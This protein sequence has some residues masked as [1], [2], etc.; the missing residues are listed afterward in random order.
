[1]FKRILV[2]IDGSPPSTA[3][4]SAAIDL[5][6]DQRALVVALNVID[7]SALPVNFEGPALPAS[8]VDAYFAA[9]GEYAR[10]LVERARTA[11]LKRG[12]KLETAVVR[13]RGR[14]VANVILAEARR[15]KAD[16]IVLGTHGRRGLKRVFMG[17][18]A[19]EVV[20]IAAVPVLLVRAK[21]RAR[22]KAEAAASVSSRREPSRAAARAADPG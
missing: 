14:T 9:Q 20:R 22:A 7:D 10:K 1:M 17:S 18:D 2:A 6:S 21:Y 5:A 3:G 4:L 13:S 12:V 19:E 15:R 16:V 11:A 8:Y